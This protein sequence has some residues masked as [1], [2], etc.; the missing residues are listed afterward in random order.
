MD[1]K[2]LKAIICA[3]RATVWYSAAFDTNDEVKLQIRDQLRRVATAIAENGGT[4]VVDLG[5]NG[6]LKR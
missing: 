1:S 5:H 3:P 4:L 6:K 2:R